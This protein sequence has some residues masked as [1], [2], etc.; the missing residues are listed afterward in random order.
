MASRRCLS[1]RLSGPIGRGSRPGRTLVCAAA[2]LNRC[3]ADR[4]EARTG[5]HPEPDR[6]PILPQ[7]DQRPPR[8]PRN[9][10]RMTPNRLDA[11]HNHPGPGPALA[12]IPATR[13]TRTVNSG[14]AWPVVL[15]LAVIV[16]KVW[17]HNRRRLQPSPDSSRHNADHDAN[18]RDDDEL[19]D[20]DPMPQPL[21]NLPFRKKIF[22]VWG[23]GVIGLPIG[24]L[25]GYWLAADYDAYLLRSVKLLVGPCTMLI[26]ASIVAVTF[27]GNWEMDEPQAQRRDNLVI[28]TWYSSCFVVFAILLAGAYAAMATVPEDPDFLRASDL[29]GL[30]ASAVALLT[31]SILG[32]IALIFRIINLVTHQAKYQKRLRTARDIPPSGS[33]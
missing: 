22:A 26:G 5:A 8:R 16:V 11:S 31:G 12:P 32:F 10:N 19:Q 4:I 27:A 13:P 9:P 3:A 7:P 17:L 29:K 24:F 25:I 23:P 18:G 15:S 2:R 21:E 1:R 28:A 33:H 20:D 30:G 14:L 6:T